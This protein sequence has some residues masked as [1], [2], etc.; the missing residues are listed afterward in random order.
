MKTP[1]DNDIQGLVFTCHISSG[2]EVFLY[3]SPT[4]EDYYCRLYDIPDSTNDV[5]L[6]SYKP[7]QYEIERGY[8]ILNINQSEEIL[9]RD[10]RNVINGFITKCRDAKIDSILP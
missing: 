6:W 8:K 3:Y 7:N 9:S 5:V 4:K 10:I 1:T 2:P